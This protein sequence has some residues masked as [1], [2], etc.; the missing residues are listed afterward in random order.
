[1]ERTRS[2]SYFMF[3]MEAWS[4]LA[5]MAEKD[6]ID[7]WHLENSNCG[8]LAKSVDYIL[9]FLDNPK[10]WKLPQITS[11]QQ[12][13]QIFLVFGGE[14]LNNS[15]MIELYR[16]VMSLDIITDEAILFFM[17]MMVKSGIF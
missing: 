10:K 13:E 2:L 14:A 9:P 7:F 15:H 12:R 6:G 4:L 17:N 5:R 3:N 16:S 8:S 11:F 1:M